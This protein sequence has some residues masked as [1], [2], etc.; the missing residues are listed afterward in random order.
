MDTK[1]KLYYVKKANNGVST[2]EY[3]SKYVK[4]GNKCKKRGPKIKKKT[5]LL[6]MVKTLEDTDI[7]KII[8]YSQQFMKKDLSNLIMV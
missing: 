6:N 2:Y 5:I 4:K 8:E 3:E 1:Y 7:L